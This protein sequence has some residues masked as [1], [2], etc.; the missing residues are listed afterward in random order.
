MAQPDQL[1]RGQEGGG[2]LV[3]GGVGT[4]GLDGAARVLGEDEVF[5]DCGWFGGCHAQLDGGDAA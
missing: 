2:H 5:W 4:A 3:H 1:V